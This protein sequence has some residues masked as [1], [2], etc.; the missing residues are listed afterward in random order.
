MVCTIQT[1]PFALEAVRKLAAAQGKRF[2][3]I[4]DEAHSSQT[5]E[6]AAKLKAVLSPE[7]LAELADGGE[8]SSVIK[9]KL[10]ESETL[11]KQAANNTKEQF[12]NSPD[13]M[14]ELLEA[15]M[16][17]LDAHTSMSTQALKSAEIQRGMKD[18]LLN[19]ARL[20]ESLRGV[21]GG[22]VPPTP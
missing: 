13:L 4:A 10:L 16:G 21:M 20:Y 3:V 14:K 11:R 1:F 19:H 12:A 5:G 17:A 18:I 22:G 15:I 8:V 7:E 9:G 2:A 6:A